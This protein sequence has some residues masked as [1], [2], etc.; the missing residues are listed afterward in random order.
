M[1]E[2]DVNDRAGHHEQVRGGHLITVMTAVKTF[3]PMLFTHRCV[4]EL[5]ILSL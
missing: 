3:H 2:I 1:L 4:T 5:H